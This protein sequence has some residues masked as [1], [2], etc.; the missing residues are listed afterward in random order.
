MLVL[1]LNEHGVVLGGL[2]EKFDRYLTR[3]TPFGFSGALLVAKKAD[4]VINKGYGMAI[5]EKGIANTA[6]T[7]FGIGS[8]TK[9][10]TAAAMMTLEMRGKLNT[11]DG[12][13]QFFSNVPKDK[14]NVTLHHLLTHTAGIIDY[15]GEDYAV[16]YRDETVRKALDAPLLFEPG[17]QYEYSNAGFT[18]LAAVIELVS[19]QPYEEYLHEH[20][21]KPS[22]MFF[23]GYRIPNWD[24]KV[25][26][27]W[28]VG[29]RSFRIDLGKPYPV[30]WNVMGNGEMLST[31]S[32]MYRWFMALKSDAILSSDAKRKLFTPFLSNYAYGWGVLKTDYGTVIGH[33]GA[34]DLGSSADFRWFVDHDTVYILLCNRSDGRSLLHTQMR[35]KFEKL[36]FSETNIELPPIVHEAAPSALKKFEG[37]YK[38]PTGGYLLLQTEAGVFKLI[39][40][41]QDAMDAVFSLEGKDVLL[42]ENLHERTA[43]LV[44]ALLNGYYEHCR[45]ELDDEERL[46]QWQRVLLKALNATDSASLAFELVGIMPWSRSE[47]DTL[48]AIV[49]LRHEKEMAEFGFLWR[50]GKL[51]GLTTG[52]DPTYMP[53]QPI[54]EDNFAGYH[55]GLAKNVQFS[56]MVDGQGG[57]LGLKIHK[58]NGDIAASRI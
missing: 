25:V 24:E 31:T 42:Y 14:E 34:N 47:K 28:Y 51:W 23:T 6:E 37:P 26:A 30:H 45:K 55:L 54:S 22:A 50:N 4:V 43:K 44:N 16:A 15:T 39:L 18:L 12:I 17:T 21:F 29:E 46:K 19:G 8:I 13:G 32:D 7:V 35:G 49:Q 11:G 56:F 10:F 27:S 41:G 36:L 52:P 58:L 53:I 33:D 40:K 38:L 20:L 48:E 5:R 1:S 2:G 57:I 9:Q 3:V